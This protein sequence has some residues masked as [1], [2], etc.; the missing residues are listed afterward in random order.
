VGNGAASFAAAFREDYGVDGPLLVD[1]GLV[2]YRAAGLR[3]GRVELLSPRLPLNAVR[4]L[5]SGHRQTD[6][7]GDPWQLG[8]VFVIHPD[9]SLRFAQRSR[10]PGDHP[11]V[12][13][14]IASLSPD[15]PEID[16]H[17]ERSAGLALLGRGLGALLDPTIALSFDRTGFAIHSLAFDPHDLD[18]ELSG[19]RALVTGANSGIG[20]E[21]AL[22]L[23]DLGAEVVLLCRD[24]ER[25]EAAAERIRAHT[26]NARVD[27][28]ALDVSDLAM[29]REVGARLAE[30]PVDILVHNAG[31]LPDRRELTAQGLER[32]FA[33]HVAGPF[34]LT[35]RLRD[36]LAA[37]GDARVVWVSS[38]GM[39]TRGLELDDPQWER[40]DSDGGYD[41]TLAYAETKRA[42][43]VLAELWHA[44]LRDQGVVVSS[45]H[46]GWA[47][48]PAV[49]SSLPRF[50]RVMRP[51]LR[52]PAEGADTVVWLAASPAAR[53]AG[54]RFWLDRQP[55]WTHLL[56]GTRESSAERRALWARCLSLVG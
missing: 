44:E 35:H 53:D 9:G 15:A 39:Y 7:Q 13:D 34:L 33:T 6:V 54:G 8:G 18:V 14:V 12:D 50:Y 49:R 24:A 25:G 47:D 11:D 46:P 26:G 3:A 21:T 55:R 41:G 56:P 23:A 28:V 36:A 29:V 43:V 19:R 51:F 22:A 38:G 5:W 27:C 52:T 4:A 31:V 42:Q 20:F 10:E 37:S 2:A 32:C 48:T 16:E 17:G 45:M 30:R 1:P 40:R